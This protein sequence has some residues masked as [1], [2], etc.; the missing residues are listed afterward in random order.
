MRQLQTVVQ[1]FLRFRRLDFTR[2]ASLQGS[3]KSFLC[4]LKRQRK[5]RKSSQPTPDIALPLAA[6]C[7]RIVGP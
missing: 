4:A 3:V 2:I 6:P 7:I 5:L 1:Y